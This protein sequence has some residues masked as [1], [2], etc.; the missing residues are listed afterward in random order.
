MIQNMLDFINQHQEAVFI[1]V[2]ILFVFGLILFTLFLS[3]GLF[4][5]IRAGIATFRPA[6]QFARA[7]PLLGLLAFIKICIFVTMT[8]TIIVLE[9]ND[10]IM[11]NQEGD[12]IY[13]TTALL[14]LIL[15]ALITSFFA[16]LID[17]SAIHYTIAALESNMISLSALV[18]KAFKSSWLLAKFVLLD[19][20]INVLTR[21]PQKQG[22]KYTSWFQFI[23]M[24]IAS[25]IGLAWNVATY[26]ITPVI[27]HE[28][29]T[30]RE[31]IRRSAEIMKKHFGT[32]IGFEMAS[33]VYFVIPFI[34]IIIGSLG[35]TCI[36]ALIR[37]SAPLLSN[38]MLFLSAIVPISCLCIV[39]PVI[40]ML[41]FITT[42]IFKSAAYNYTQGKSTGP[43]HEQIAQAALRKTHM[44]QE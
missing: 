38:S 9:K 3:R 15:G 12:A 23:N 24:I 41:N 37:Y 22:K 34:L 40:L 36:A 18:R 43:F 26:F 17:I 42:W 28:R 8:V 21:S 30:L 39:T 19:F 32:T 13:T 35:I 31:S 4:K 33:I 27:A 2:S 44:P 20:V 16:K 5:N 14:I 29:V 7:H 6:L 1:T 11:R 25:T 10:F